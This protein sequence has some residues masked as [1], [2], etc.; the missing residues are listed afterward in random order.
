MAVPYY[1]TVFPS[2]PEEKSENPR[3]RETIVW[4]DRVEVREL[5]IT[6]EQT[7]EGKTTLFED[8]RRRAVR[9]MAD[10]VKAPHAACRSQRGHRVQRLGRIPLSPRAFGQYIPGLRLVGRIEVETRTAEQLTV[11]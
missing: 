4:L 3:V 11:F 5:C 10:R 9:V 7:F 8:A 6:P 2:V 1:A